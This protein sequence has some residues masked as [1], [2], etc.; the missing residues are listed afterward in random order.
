MLKFLGVLVAL[1]C[2][3]FASLVL[4]KMA[5]GGLEHAKIEDR[6]FPR[7]FQRFVDLFEKYLDRLNRTIAPVLSRIMPEMTMRSTKRATFWSLLSLS[8]TIPF[9][10][11]LDDFAGY[12]PLFSVVNVFG[13][14]VGVFVGHMILNA[15]LYL[16]P[17]RTIKVVKNPVISLIGSFVFVGLG[18]W[19]LSEVV[20]LFV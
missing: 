9:I 1:V 8:F 20:R 3:W 6:H 16:S 19:G 15:L 7:W 4:F 10:L 5:E 17:A 12:V 18:I 2:V 14:S 11:G 13:F